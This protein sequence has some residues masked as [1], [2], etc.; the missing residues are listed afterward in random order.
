MKQIVVTVLVWVMIAQIP[1]GAKAQVNEAAQL[2]LNIEKLAQLKSI[3]TTLKKGFTIVS[4]G[5]GTVKSLTQGNF[6]LHQTFLDGLLQVSPAIKKYYKVAGIIEY[7]IQL[8]KACKSAGRRLNVP[9]LF[10]SGEISYM[11]GV[12]ENLGASSLKNLDELLNVMTANSLRMSDDERLAAIDKLYADMEDK[13]SFIRSFNG[14]CS[15]LALERSKEINQ[16]RST[17]TLYSI[18][19]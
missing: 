13:L 3:L 5:Y 2:A 4:K 12:Y 9:E 1:I 14:S 10:N 6:S 18:E 17:G 11:L 8:V 16:V 19:K 15:L 7:Q